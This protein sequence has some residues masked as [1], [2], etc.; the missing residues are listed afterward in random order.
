M[1]SKRVDGLIVA[2]TGANSDLL[3]RMRSS[4]LPIV[5]IDRASPGFAAPLVGIDN[6]RASCDA[7][8]YLLGRGHA[9]IGLLAGLPHVSTIVERVQ[10][11]RD[12]YANH[13]LGVDESLIRY[14]NSRAPSA[15]VATQQLLSIEPPISALVGTV[16]DLTLGAVQVLASL[17]RLNP[18]VIS[19]LS[20]DDPD[21]AA[22]INPPLTAVR[23]PSYKMGETA[24]RTL[25]RLIAGDDP[26]P[27]QICLETELVI[28]SSVCDRP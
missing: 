4:G 20:F 15:R 2:P 7:I 18:D 23:Q 5:L 11:Y 21:W 1:W 17:N 6:R 9:R 28:R 3:A 16:S 22:V 19:L 10:G 12:A 14:T 25:L 27:D 13:G 26:A 8:S 24:A